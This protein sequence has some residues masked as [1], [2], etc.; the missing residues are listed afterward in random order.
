MNEK[1][2]DFSQVPTTAIA[3]AST[4][5]GLNLIMEGIGPFEPF[6]SHRV[7]APAFTMR[8]APV[9]SPQGGRASL[10][11]ILEEIPTGAFVVLAG[12]GTSLAVLGANGARVIHRSGAAGVVADGAARD[13]HEIRELGLPVWNRSVR[14]LP[15]T[16]RLEL[17][18]R[19]VP[20]TCGGVQVAPGDTVVADADGVAV[21]PRGRAE[22]VR[23]R[24]EIILAV[25]REF[26]ERFE[27]GES[28][29]VLAEMMKRKWR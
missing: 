3:D 7:A 17:I 28:A 29:Q 5:L 10:Y 16:R 20:I 27:K 19:D 6:T 26:N 12:G 18:E 13:V 14:S 2:A 22:A 24:V 23:E 4:A 25:E 11:D 15:Y 8:F 21:V 1:L 9:Q